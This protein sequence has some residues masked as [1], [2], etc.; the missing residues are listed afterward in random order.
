MI[1]DSFF[2]GQFGPEPSQSIIM[3]GF[4]MDSLVRNRSAH[5][6]NKWT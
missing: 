6:N 5:I 4:F 1:M 3:D 2:Y